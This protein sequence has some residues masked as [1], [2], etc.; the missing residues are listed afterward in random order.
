MLERSQVDFP[1]WRKKVDSTLIK[2][3]WT[4]IPKWLKK[5]WNIDKSFENVRSKGAPEA[6]VDVIFNKVIYSGQ[7]AKVKRP[8]GYQFRLYFNDEL[9]TELRKT[10]PMTLMRSLEAELSESLNHRAVEE[11]FHFGSF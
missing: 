9:T 7:V 8:D 1:M 4:P 6:E 3:G 2:H 10:Y 5:F 11:K